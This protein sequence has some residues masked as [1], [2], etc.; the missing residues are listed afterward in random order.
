MRGRIKKKDNPNFD[1]G[2]IYIYRPEQ[3]ICYNKKSATTRNLPQQE[4]CH[5]KKSATTKNLL[6]Q[7]IVLLQQQTI[8]LITIL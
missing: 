4:I 2:A 1:F 5:N 8:S 3:E 7:E 6:Q